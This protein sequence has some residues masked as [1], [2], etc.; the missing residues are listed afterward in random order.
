[1]L[2]LLHQDRS[3]NT[4]ARMKHLRNS[5]GGQ[6]QQKEARLIFSSALLNAHAMTVVYTAEIHCVLSQ[7]HFWLD[8]VFYAHF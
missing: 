8:F 6:V 2:D 1:M 5:V 4:Q 3:I 7:I